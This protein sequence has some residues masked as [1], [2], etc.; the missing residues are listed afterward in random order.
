MFLLLTLNIFD[1]FFECFT[2]D[3]EQ[4]NVSWD[5]S[6]QNLQNRLVHY[7]LVFNTFCTTIGLTSRSCSRKQI[8]WEFQQTSQANIL[9]FKVSKLRKIRCSWE[10]S[11]KFQNSYFIEH[12]WTIIFPSATFLQLKCDSWN[13]LKH[14]NC[15]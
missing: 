8:F 11:K 5:N 13:I 1:T 7:N 2:D 4:V 14:F 9:E 10:L 15:N 3:F 6:V 12:L